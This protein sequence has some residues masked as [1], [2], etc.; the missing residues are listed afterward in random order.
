MAL[1]IG[2]ALVGIAL[3]LWVLTAGAP[4]EAAVVISTVGLI[5]VIGGAALEAVMWQR[6]RR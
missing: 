1:G 4:Q 5:V 3:Q 2:V 6:R